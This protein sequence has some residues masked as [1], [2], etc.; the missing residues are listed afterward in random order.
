MEAANGLSFLIVGSGSIGKR[1]ARNLA[2][3]GCAISCTDPRD[4]RRREL[5][6][7]VPVVGGFTDMEAALASNIDFDGVVIC[8]PPVA[9]VEQALMALEAEIPVLLEKPVAPDLGEGQMLRTACATATV[10]L[11]LGYTWRWWPPIVDFRQRLGD[12]AIGALRHVR[13][14]MSAH[15][16]DWHPWERYQDFFMAHRALGGGA[17]LDE[18]HWIDLML[19]FFGKPDWISADASRVSDLE[20]DVD[21]NIDIIAGFGSGLRVT[22]HLD[23]Y[24]RPHEKSITAIGSEGTLVWRENPNR[25]SYAHDASPLW[26]NTDYDC[27]RNDMFLAVAQEFIEVVDA[28]LSPSCTIADGC[29]VLSVVEAVRRSSAEG[30][31]IMMGPSAG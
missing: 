13:F 25:V 22:V 20:I 24:G 31:R 9:H 29:D 21:D 5:A 2:S 12:G 14:V 26:Q 28:D 4:D 3:L 16:A 8:S 1:H 30:R 10:P 18:S 17:L 7:E 27:E 6:G 15:L 23:L 11:L 19:W